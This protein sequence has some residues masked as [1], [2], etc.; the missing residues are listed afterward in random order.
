M[1]NFD[2][3]LADK[4]KD[5]R[6]AQDFLNGIIK[7]Y[8]EDNDKELFLACLKDFVMLRGGMTEI[9]RKTKINRQHLYKI[10]SPSGNPTLENLRAI[11]L[12]L[13]FK[14]KVEL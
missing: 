12:A 7:D 2:D 8:Y 4:L 1:I 9:S 11:L 6:F 3:Y 10:F 14:I 5:D 13:G